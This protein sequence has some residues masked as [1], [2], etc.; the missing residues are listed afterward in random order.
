METCFHLPAFMEYHLN[1]H[2]FKVLKVSNL[3]KNLILRGRAVGYKIS[4]W[5]AVS[6]L[7]AETSLRTSGNLEYVPLDFQMK[8]KPIV[9]HFLDNTVHPG[10]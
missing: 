9:A 5:M 2:F 10:S 6:S 1:F 8:N 3:I 4:S 7:T